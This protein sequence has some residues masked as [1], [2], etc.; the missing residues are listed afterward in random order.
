VVPRQNYLP[1]FKF[2]G[3]LWQF[4][5]WWVDEEGNEMKVTGGEVRFYFL[6]L[7]VLNKRFLDAPLSIKWNHDIR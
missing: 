2:Q 4:H 6:T 3:P 7:F 5:L 1:K